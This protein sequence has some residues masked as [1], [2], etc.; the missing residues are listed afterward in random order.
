MAIASKSSGVGGKWIDKKV[1]KTGDVAKIKTEAT[2]QA[3]QQDGKTQW[4]C[5]LHVK[6]QSEPLNFAIN[7][8]S[9]N[10]L[11]DAFG[12]DTNDWIDKV[13][14]L[15]IEKTLIAG[16]RGLAAYLIPEG[17]EMTE[18]SGGYIVITR[19]GA[20]RVKSPQE[21]EEEIDIDSVPL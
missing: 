8:Q 3:S 16:K 7:S 11:I 5:K 2:E 18:D 10:A 1:L 15:E 20:P 14:T 4:V 21:I 17:F 12:A 13:L 6:G 19:K 9:K